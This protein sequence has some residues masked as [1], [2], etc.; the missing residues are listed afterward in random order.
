[1]GRVEIELVVELAQCAIET[2]QSSE[3]LVGEGAGVTGQMGNPF[4]DQRG[5]ISQ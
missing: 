1:M 4:L 2:W 3:L 5:G